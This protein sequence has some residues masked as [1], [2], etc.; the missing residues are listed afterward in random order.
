VV[1]LTQQPGLHDRDPDGPHSDRP[2]SQHTRLAIFDRSILLS[3]HQNLNNPRLLAT[4][5]AMTAR[6]GD[7]HYEFVNAPAKPR[8]ARIPAAKWEELR[9][10][11]T[12][13]YLSSNLGEVVSEMQTRHSFYAK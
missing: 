4:A 2:Q 10:E 9:A 12:E 5:H 6:G 13:I 3:Q 11:A 8:T 7:L 1:C